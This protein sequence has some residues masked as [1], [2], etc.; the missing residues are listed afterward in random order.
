MATFKAGI[1]GVGFI[2][3]AH[4]DAL[5]RLGNV[6][7]VALAGSDERRARAKADQYYVPRAYGDYRR[8]LEDPEIDVVHNCTPNRYHYAI[9]RAILQAGKHC[10]SEKPLGLTSAETAAL[11]QEARRSGKVAA[12]NFNHRGYPL[13]QQARAAVA[14]GELGA[15][16]LVYGGYY[17]DWLLYDTDYNWRVDPAIGGASRAVA[18]IGSHWTDLVQYVTGQELTA[19]CA[20]LQTFLPT[21]RRPTTA[22]ATF[23]GQERE[24]AG[25]PVAIA[26]EDAASVLL[27]FDAGAR[28]CLTVSQLTAGRKNRLVFELAGS[29]AALAWDGEEPDR[30]WVGHRDAPNAA[31]MRDP[32]LLAEPARPYAR[33]PAGHAEG[34]PDALKNVLEQVY[35]AVAGDETADYPTFAAGD[36]AARV[37]EAILRSSR[38]ER[39]R[40]IA[41]PPPT[42]STGT[43]GA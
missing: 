27:R 15:V 25:E 14:A 42:E 1:I 31:V 22:T 17:Q 32:A 8:L 23:A 29:R 3:P 38:D 33:L 41:D 13:I 11:L 28:G 9:N 43:R 39:W 37:V 18:D 6:E 16:R 40:A 21:R 24:P 30:L 10:V 4:L 5:R 36:R 19:V 2:G 26:S 7:V 20:D 35:R 34:W 12:V